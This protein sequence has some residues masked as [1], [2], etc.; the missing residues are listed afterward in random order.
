MRTYR[1]SLRRQT[2]HVYIDM[3]T[4][5]LM[6]RAMILSLLMTLSAILADSEL[7]TDFSSTLINAADASNWLP[8]T[9][10]LTSRHGW[11][12]ITLTAWSFDIN[13]MMT[14]DYTR[15]M[16]PLTQEDEFNSDAQHA[17]LHFW[18]RHCIDII[19]NVLIF[20]W[21]LLTFDTHYYYL[22]LPGM[23]C[24]YYNF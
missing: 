3:I 16:M 14:Y 12:L 7:N 18:S 17:W 20:T 19:F 11:I 6:I 10:W 15:V 24:L 21:F 4:R 9:R 1:L 13:S 8:F 23:F 5:P 2:E 22:I